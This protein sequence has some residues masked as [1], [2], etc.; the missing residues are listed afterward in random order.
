MNYRLNDFAA[1]EV[2][3]IVKHYSQKSRGLSIGFIEELARVLTLLAANPYIGEAIG[4]QYRHLSLQRLPYF[5]IYQV[6]A[7]VKRI[8]VI[9]VCHHRRHPDHWRSGIHEQPAVYRLAA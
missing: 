2:R 9:S 5:V 3:D 1:A 8:S 6:A 4:E 7:P